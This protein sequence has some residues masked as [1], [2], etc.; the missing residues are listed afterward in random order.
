MTTKQTQTQTQTQKKEEILLPMRAYV[1]FPAGQHL[2][3]PSPPSSPRISSPRYRYG[4]TRSSNI[5]QQQQQ[6][7]HLP[8]V[9]SSSSNAT[10]ATTSANFSHHQGI[11]SG[12]SFIRITRTFL[13]RFTYLILS[14][15]LKRHVLFL[16]APLV[17]ISG[18]LYMGT[19]PME[20]PVIVPISSPPPG[21]VYRSHEVF[22]NLW[23][24]MKNSNSSFLV[25]KFLHYHVVSVSLLDLLIKRS[26]SISK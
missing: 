4:R 25:S 14:L 10:T 11:F 8:S 22:H 15:L 17:Y 24:Q 2:N 5:M 7:G 6:G 18:M 23:P 16:I 1:R 19:I 20:S 9:S 26:V 12:S 13:Q 3:V 21:S